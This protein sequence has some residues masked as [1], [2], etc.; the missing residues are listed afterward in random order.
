MARGSLSFLP[1]HPPS[2]TAPSGCRG[3]PAFVC[4][5]ALQSAYACARRLL[6]SPLPPLPCRSSHCHDEQARQ[7]RRKGEAREHKQLRGGAA[8]IHHHPDTARSAHDNTP[9]LPCACRQ[10][11]APFPPLKAA[12]HGNTGPE[13]GGEV[14]LGRRDLA[15]RHTSRKLLRACAP[16][17]QQPSP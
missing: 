1:R 8:Y 13:T 15:E 17:P 6:P 12:Q 14:L 7:G 10:T 9:R 16:S 4:V 11:K 5:L 2:T 3:A